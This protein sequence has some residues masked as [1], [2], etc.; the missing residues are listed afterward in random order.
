MTGLC[1]RYTLYY[2]PLWWQNVT[3]WR[4]ELFPSNDTS[5]SHVTFSGKHKHVLHKGAIRAESRI[6]KS[7]NRQKKKKALKTDIKVLGLLTLKMKVLELDIYQTARRNKPQDLTPQQIAL[8]ISHTDVQAVNTRCRPTNSCT[9]H[10]K[11]FR[12]YSEYC[13]CEVFL[14]ATCNGFARRR[15]LPVRQVRK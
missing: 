14:A 5:L 12:N 10:S 11:L 7:G 3:R 6:F 13:H 8:R 9:P 2:L 15:P 4:T 1:I